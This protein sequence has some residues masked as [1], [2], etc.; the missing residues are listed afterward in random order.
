MESICFSLIYFFKGSLPW[1]GLI[2]NNSSDK[3]RAITEKKKATKAEELCEGCPLEFSIFLNYVRSLRFADKPDYGY[4]RGLLK[5]ILLRECCI[6]DCIYDWSPQKPNIQETIEEEELI[7]IQ[8]SN[9][10]PN[11]D[12]QFTPRGNIIRKGS[13]HEKENEKKEKRFLFIKAKKKK[14]KAKGSKKSQ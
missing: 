14:K 13:E 1:Q 8:R 2:G 6:Y 11:P 12:P 5:R 9:S 7:P 4:L 10:D 3:F